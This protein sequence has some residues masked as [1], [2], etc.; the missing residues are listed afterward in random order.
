MVQTIEKTN[1]YKFVSVWDLPDAP[2]FG[3]SCKLSRPDDIVSV[4]LRQLLYSTKRGNG[5][6]G[7]L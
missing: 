2:C 4:F 1:H 7:Y 3:D 5:L 6:E